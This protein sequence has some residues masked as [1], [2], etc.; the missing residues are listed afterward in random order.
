MNKINA[1]RFF[2]KN[3]ADLNN[4]FQTFKDFEGTRV[5]AAGVFCGEK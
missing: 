2:L 3:T 1:Q 5:L 4:K